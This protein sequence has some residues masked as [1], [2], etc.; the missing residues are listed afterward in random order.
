M[1]MRS[2]ASA[3]HRW[4]FFRTGGFDQVCIET[5]DDL[6]HLDQLDQKLWAV[7]TVPTSGLEFDEHTL[8]LIDRRS[9]GCVRVPDLLA[10]VK[11]TCDVL[12][13]P[14]ILF[15]PGDSLPLQ[16]L[17]EGHADGAAVAGAAR[18]L[19]AALGRPD[20][21]TVSL[22]DLSDTS[23]LFAANQFNGDGVV[24]PG[25]SADPDVAAAIATIVGAQGGVLDRSGEPGLDQAG[26]EAFV[27]A[28]R[29]VCDW[30]AEG[31][32]STQA[33]APGSAVMA[34]GTET[35]AA[36]AAFDAVQAK[37]EDY[38]T[39][40]RLAAFDPRAAD[41]LN[42]TEQNLTDLSA[43]LLAADVQAIAA[44]PLAL[45]HAEALLPLRD[46]LNPAWSTAIGALRD[47]VVTPVLGEVGT[48][49]SP[50]WQTLSAR[51][52]A[53]RDW[54]ASRP[55]TPVADLDAS[56]LRAFVASDMAERIAALIQ[57]DTQAGGA[58]QR[59]VHGGQLGPHG[60]APGAADLDQGGPHAQAGW[61]W[62]GA[63]LS[64]Q[65]AQHGALVQAHRDH[66]ERRLPVLAGM[67]QYT[68]RCHQL[69]R[70]GQQHGLQRLAGA[71]AL[72]ASVGLHREEHMAA[73]AAPA[74]QGRDGIGTFGHGVQAGLECGG[75]GHRTS[76]ARS[77]GGYSTKLLVCVQRSRC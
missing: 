61:Q 19:L 62:R 57:A 21:P 65:R 29:A 3:A 24:V 5:A 4:K 36:A 34:W 37:V 77:R 41:A 11:W 22:A 13:D 23:A 25:L 28:A 32:A 52:Q 50:Q 74:A 38:F 20:D 72:L 70:A 31:E 58:A 63:V 14:Q 47:L 45:V 55:V 16:A 51:L 1:N 39:R 48:L 26:L 18:A 7:L 6:R 67:H 42:A 64:E 2:D 10:A 73:D 12:R 9:E 59:L 68:C 35:A 15:E 17:D 30:R 46:G 33:D 60:F 44:L 8:Q 75:L 49:S 56:A 27:A 43:G 53:W 54:Y 71:A 69:P 40:C 66:R 76:L